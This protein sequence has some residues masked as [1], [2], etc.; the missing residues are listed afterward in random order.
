M[1]ILFAVLVAAFAVLAWRDLRL[2]LV[3][4]AGVL[5]TYLLRFSIGPI[6]TTLLECFVLVAAIVWVLRGG[7][8]RLPTLRQFAPQAALLFAASFVAVLVAPDQ[9][10]ALGLWRAYIVEP[11]LLFA[12]L[13]TTFQKQDWRHAFVALAVSSVIIAV[14]GIFQYFTGIGIPSPWDIE[15]RIT[16][17]FD[18]PNALGLFL[19][20]IAAMLLIARKRMAIVALVVILVAIILAK[21]EAALVAIPAAAVITLWLTPVRLRTKILVT[22]AAA[23]MLAAAFAIPAVQEKLLL[24]DVSGQT[25]LAIWRETADMLADRPLTGAGLS[26][27]PSTIAAYHD[28][29]FY[30]IF[31]Y[32][33]NVILNIWTELGLIGLVATAAIALTA[34]RIAYKK[35]RD[36]MVLAVF[37]ALL[38]MAIH[39]LVDVPFF[40]N[41]LALLTAG[42]LA[43]LTW[44]T[45]PSPTSQSPS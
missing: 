25:R 1:T 41:D 21:T 33:H 9:L 40:K 18:F 13:A 32:P 7:L 10:D 12:I 28:P 35:R 20:P 17:I 38:T 29:T 19:A 3:L 45:I 42:L 6:P 37:A 22:L 31:Q 24:Q 26:G 4:L 27:F 30:E 44:R 39:G 34:C 8:A 43:F 14:F 23:A 36:P 11:I 15:R 16:S 5:P 2:A